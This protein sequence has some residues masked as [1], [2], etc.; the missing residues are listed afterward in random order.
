MATGY[1]SFSRGDFILTKQRAE[2]G[3]TAHRPPTREADPPGQ[4]IV[5]DVFSTP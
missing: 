1:L 2:T 5:G 4:I 3:L